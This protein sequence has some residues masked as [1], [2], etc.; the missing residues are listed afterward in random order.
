[1]RKLIFLPIILVLLS[2]NVFAEK[3]ID[4]ATY[5]RQRERINSMLDVRSQKF[6]RYDQSLTERTGIFGLQTKKDIKRSNEILMDIVKADN[7]IYAQLKILLDYRVFQQKQA[8]DRS[9][10]AE[11]ESLESMYTIARLQKQLEKVKQQQE[12]LQVQSDKSSM[13]FKI[14]L[15]VLVLIIL[16]LLSL[17]LRRKERS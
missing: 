2:A 17:Q 5:E 1:M 15:G 4:S 16:V 3:D 9:K 11:G 10:Q 8:A 6:S 13:N 7:D 14:S 12:E